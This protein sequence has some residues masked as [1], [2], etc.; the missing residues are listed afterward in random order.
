[1]FQN[2][3]SRVVLC[4]LCA[5]ALPA[6][7]TDPAV[8]TL[9]QTLPTAT[10]YVPAPPDAP[11]GTCWGQALV[12]AIIQTV[13]EQVQ[14]SPKIT[15]PDGTVESPAIF[16]T[17]TRQEILRPRGEIRF[18]AVCPRDLTP[19]FIASLQRAMAARG[20]FSGPVT[21]TYDPATQAAIRALQKETGPDSPI[22]STDLARKLGLI[23][24]ETF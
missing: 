14:V 23:A 19:G 1:M 9:P 10:G 22:L 20:A 3:F 6:C 17:E 5:F 15:A 8:V 11:R 12:P 24:V 4:A 13:T 7:Q 16:R 2:D 21:A 18:Q